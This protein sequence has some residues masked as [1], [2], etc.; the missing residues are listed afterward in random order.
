MR[1]IRVGAATV[2]Q[3][4]LDWEGN[5]ARMRTAMAEAEQAGVQFLVFP[6]L[7]LTGYGCEDAFHGL[8]HSRRAEKHLVE[9]AKSVGS[10][11]VVAGVPIRLQHGLYNCAAFLAQGRIVG[12]VAKQHLPG[13]GVHYEPRWFRGWTAGRRTTV[14]IGGAAVPFGDIVLDFGGVR[15]GAEICE[16]AWVPG[17]V[18]HQLA[19]GGCDLIAGPSASHFSFGKHEIRERVVIEGSRSALAC[20]VFAN[21]LGNEAGRMIFDG[22]RVI[23]AGGDVLARS[24]LLT[25]REVAVTTAVVDVDLLRMRRARTTSL[26]PSDEKVHLVE[27]PWTW[28]QADAAPTKPI[29]PAT[30]WVAGPH[31]KEEEFARA[32]ALGLHDYQRKSRS[33][34]FVVSLSGGAD[35]AAVAALAALSYRM[36][37]TEL[38]TEEVARR[39]PGTAPEPESFCG[40]LLDTVYQASANSGDETRDAAQAV[41]D[42]IGARH[43][44]WDIEELVQGYRARVEETL[45]RPLTWK[46]DDIALQNIQARVRAPGIWMLT[47]VRGALLL[48]TSNRSEAAVGY[49]TMDG[50]TAGSI[51]PIAGIDKNYLRKWL[52]WLAET[53]PEGIGPIPGVMAVCTIP[54]KAELRPQ[55]SNQTDEGDLMPYDLLDAVERLAIRDRMEPAEVLASLEAEWAPRTGGREALAAHVRKFFALW[56]R[57]QWKRERYA[58]SFHLDDENLDPKTWCRFPI[59]SGGFQEELNE[60][61]R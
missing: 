52:R 47:N 60:L 40:G 33:R 36:A 1:W 11:I 30:G 26:K 8:A 44:V 34:G 5:L 24:E 27:V 56:C 13:D 45:G 37:A 17:R 9:F 46:D 12:I 14:E 15:A 50:D 21:A 61:S 39:L 54:P 48:A 43:A 42:G 25:F 28:K 49:A 23:A 35:S 41:A 2:N 18:A 7:S 22:Q 51:S 20:H 4:P 38:G 31:R 3:T 55:E 29:G 16:D 32:V 53:G 19:M 58:P 6:E 10:M 59:L 57:N